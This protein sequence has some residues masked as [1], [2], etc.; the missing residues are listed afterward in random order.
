MSLRKIWKE[1]YV[2]SP[3]EIGKLEKSLLRWQHIERLISSPGWKI[4]EEEI[5]DKLKYES[6]VRNADSNNIEYKKGC[7]DGIQYILTRI[8]HFK[9]VAEEAQKALDSVTQ[10]K[11]VNNG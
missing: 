11:E 6:D 9:R 7:C 2:M 10:K 5:S 8:K 4:I 1:K 3:D